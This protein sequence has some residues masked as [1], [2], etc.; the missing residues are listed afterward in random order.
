MT[1]GVTGSIGSGKSTVCRLFGEW[2]ATVID[3]DQIAHHA[4]EEQDVQAAIVERFGGDLL[5]EGRLDRRELG[6]RAF[7]TDEDRVA[8]TDIVWPAVGRLLKK[9]A[10]SADSDRPIVI[11]APVLLEWGDPDGLCEVV[12]VV[13]AAEVTRV[14]RTVARLGISEKEVRDRARHQ[15]P[16]AEKVKHANHVIVNDSDLNTLRERACRLWNTL[17]DAGN[18]AR[19][20]IGNRRAKSSGT[21]NGHSA[22]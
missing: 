16:E 2:G 3:A 21:T 12:V 15:M 11:E 6:R 14:A 1:I 17:V 18:T 7:A 20:G 10:E 4:L 9:C 5:A 13:T 8:L 22:A 19:E